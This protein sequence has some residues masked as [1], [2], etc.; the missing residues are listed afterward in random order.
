M[1]AHGMCLL[2]G[3]VKLVAMNNL[4]MLKAYDA[5]KG[6][7][8]HLNLYGM[9]NSLERGKLVTWMDLIPNEVVIWKVF[10]DITYFYTS[11]SRGIVPLK[12]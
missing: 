11:E 8:S 2:R 5:T 10:L 9:I 6:Q 7:R 3:L 1:Y 4:D 12:Q